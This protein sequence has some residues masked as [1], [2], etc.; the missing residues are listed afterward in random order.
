MIRVVL[1]FLFL[2]VLPARQPS[3]PIYLY[4]ECH[5]MEKRLELATCFLFTNSFTSILECADLGPNQVQQWPYKSLDTLDLIPYEH[6]T[7]D[8]VWKVCHGSRNCADGKL[9]VT[10]RGI[11]LAALDSPKCHECSLRSVFEGCPDDMT[12]FQ[13][14]LCYQGV[15]QEDIDCITECAELRGQAYPPWGDIWDCSRWDFFVPPTN[16][17]HYARDVVSNPFAY[18]PLCVLQANLLRNAF[19]VNRRRHR[20]T[21]KP[22]KLAAIQGTGSNM[23]RT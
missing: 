16:R 17:P 20:P 23:M 3:C 14:C 4:D 22:N 7:I 10:P 12:L 19:L 18:L 11:L 9:S 15:L 21:W 5:D 8:N 2:R 6:Y 1:F 13:G